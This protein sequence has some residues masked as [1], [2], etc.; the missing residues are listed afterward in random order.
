MEEFRITRV[1]QENRFEMKTE[2]FHSTCYEFYYQ[3]SGC[4][5]IFLNDRIYRVE[6]GDLMLIP[7]GEIHRTTYFS[8]V[9]RHAYQERIALT[10]EDDMIAH[11]KEQIGEQ[12]FWSCFYRRHLSVPAKRRSYLEEL[13]ERLLTEYRGIDDF[14][15]T[16]CRMYCEEIVLF[17]IRCQKDVSL[18]ENLPVSGN[19]EMEEAAQ[20]ISSHFSENLTLKVMAERSC[21]SSTYFSRQFKQATGFGF[22]EYLSAVRIRHACDLLLSTEKSITEIAAEC[23][24]MD[25]NYFGDAFRKAKNL[26]PR[27]YRRA[28]LV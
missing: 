15:K 7:K 4:R 23:G 18:K 26:S 25:S 12:A 13:F 24:Y 14:S 1:R 19:R 3:V 2:H 21:M 8:D 5:K 20:F 11:L 10:F 6:K 17:V 16:M 28:Y 9:D 27:E 22:K